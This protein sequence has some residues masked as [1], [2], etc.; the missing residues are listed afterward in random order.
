MMVILPSSVDDSNSTITKA[1]LVSREQF[2]LA[3]GV[4]VEIV[5]RQLPRRLPGSTHHFKYRV[6]LIAR[7]VC[8]L[9]YDN[10]AGKGDHKHI[11]EREEPYQF[12]DLER[13]LM[14]FRADV[15]A[16]RARQ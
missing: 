1:D 5:V 2:L 8:V 16:W 15:E 6:A 11:A 7:G 13:L 3:K 10:E 9:R 4:R 12:F 14:D